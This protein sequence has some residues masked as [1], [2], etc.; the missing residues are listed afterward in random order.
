[1]LQLTR[2]LIPCSFKSP[3]IRHGTIPYFSLFYPNSG[4][5]PHPNHMHSC[6]HPKQPQ[7]ERYFLISPTDNPKNPISPYNVSFFFECRY[8]HFFHSHENLRKI[9]CFHM[10]APMLHG[11]SIRT[12]CFVR[13]PIAPILHGASHRTI[14]RIPAKYGNLPRT[15]HHTDVP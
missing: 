1:M 13:A 10:D 12:S 5:Q 6:P 11:S 15:H 8:I 4:A 2:A 7:A 3:R 9:D 14:L